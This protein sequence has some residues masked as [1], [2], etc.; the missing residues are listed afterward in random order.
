MDSSALSWLD[1]STAAAV[2]EILSPDD[3]S[4]QKLPFYA[5]HHVDEVLFVDPA[6]RTITGSHCAPAN[7]SLSSEAG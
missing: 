3:E 2:V 5:E 7:T 6:Q 4:W 1:P